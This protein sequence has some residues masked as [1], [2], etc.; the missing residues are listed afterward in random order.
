M[1]V[2]FYPPSFQT[3]S[4]LERGRLKLGRLHVPASLRS[5]LWRSHAPAQ[6]SFSGRQNQRS[7]GRIHSGHDGLHRR[8]VEVSS[9]LSYLQR[10]SVYAGSRISFLNG[11]NSAYFFAKTNKPFTLWGIC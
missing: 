4:F 11:D 8:E 1:R 3:I 2:L 7:C 9:F 6:E 5:L 10:E